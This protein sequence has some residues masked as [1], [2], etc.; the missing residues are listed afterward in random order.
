MGKRMSSQVPCRR[1]DHS[2]PEKLLTSQLL[3]KKVTSKFL[4][5]KEEEK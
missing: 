4:A 5:K 1:G 3:A 2:F